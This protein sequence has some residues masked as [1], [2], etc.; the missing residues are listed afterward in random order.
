MDEKGLGAEPSLNLGITNL[1]KN[2][3]PVTT[4]LVLFHP[5]LVSEVFLCKFVLLDRI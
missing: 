4:I 3:N 1:P 2:Y 5:V